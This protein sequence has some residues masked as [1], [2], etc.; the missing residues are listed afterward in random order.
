M[1]RN[2]FMGQRILLRSEDTKEPTF[3]E[4]RV[5]RIYPYHVLAER[6]IGDS[7]IYIRRSI[8]L[9]Q[10]ILMGLEKQSDEIEAKRKEYI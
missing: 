7:D 9:G 1:I 2:V 6:R 10:L 5:I 4:Y 3:D 8:S